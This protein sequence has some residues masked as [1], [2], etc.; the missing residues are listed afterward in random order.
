MAR[1]PHQQFVPKLDDKVDDGDF[2]AACSLLYRWW[3]LLEAPEGTDTSAF[4]DGLLDERVTVQLPD[5]GVDLTGREAVKQLTAAFPPGSKRS[6]AVRDDAIQVSYLGDGLY[7]LQAQYT[8]QLQSPDGR[9]IS[10]HSEC[11]AVLRKDAR[12]RMVFTK[13]GG[14]RGAPIEPGGFESS[15]RLHRI[16]AVLLQW[17]AHMD[18][19]SGDSSGL[20]ELVMPELEF[21]GLIAAKADHSKASNTVVKDF[22]EMKGMLAGTD[23]TEDTVIRG[24]EG[25][26]RWFA[27][28][29]SLL[30]RN[31][32]RGEEFRISELPDNRYDVVAQ[33][34]WF[35]ETLNGVEIELHQPLEWVIVERGEKYMRLE[36]LRPHSR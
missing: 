26:T 35:A 22:T 15:Y 30:K 34:G 9:V 33:F 13:I 2:N 7:R 19:L 14:K 6:H 28:G 1:T 16:K 11:D 36:K 20:K 4:F 24:F 10:G 17:Q 31:I 21:H 27:T 32:H 23:G 3:G 25:V 18:T 12:A 5:F 8:Y 29:P